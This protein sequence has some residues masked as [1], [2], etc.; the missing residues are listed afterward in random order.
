MV[1]QVFFVGSLALLLSA[2]APNSPSTEAQRA[3]VADGARV[4]LRDTN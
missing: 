3:R 2:C 1:K 4:E